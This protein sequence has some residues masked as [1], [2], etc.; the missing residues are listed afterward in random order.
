MNQ[1]KTDV[2]SNSGHLRGEGRREGG[3]KRGEGSRV[4]AGEVGEEGE[5]GE[6]EEAGEAGSQLERSTVNQK[7]GQNGNFRRTPN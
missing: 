4:E 2:N 6:A 5:V 1:V 3:T 7:G